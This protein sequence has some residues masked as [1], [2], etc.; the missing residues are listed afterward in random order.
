MPAVQVLLEVWQG[1][2][3]DKEDMF[4]MG[5]MLKNSKTNSTGTLR[6]SNSQAALSCDQDIQV[7]ALVSCLDISPI[8]D[9]KT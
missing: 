8:Q 4:A 3:Q 1:Y 2:S 9:V 6:W 7:K 5:L